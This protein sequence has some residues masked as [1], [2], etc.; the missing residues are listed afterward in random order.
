MEEEGKIGSDY[1]V[2]LSVKSDLERAAKSDCL[3]D[4]IDYVLLQKIV[5]EEMAVRS[6]L[7]EHVGSR[8]IESIFNQVP[9]A[10][11]VKVTVSKLNPPIGGD[12]EEVSVIMKS[13]R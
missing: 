13:K 1:L 6:K 5:K 8:I 3:S 4:T 2:N 10:Q 7:L 12:V 11:S 9:L